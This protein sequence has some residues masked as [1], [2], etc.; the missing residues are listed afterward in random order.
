MKKG[1]VL[2]TGGAGFIGSHLCDALLDEEYTVVV[3]D[4]LCTGKKENVP[5]KAEFHEL[6]IC[7]EKIAD[8]FAQG[9][10]NA[11]CHLAAQNDV[12]TSVSKPVFD[13]QVN[14][15]GSINLLQN[16]VKANVKR[17]VFAST[18]G[19]IYGEA[20]SLPVDET[21][22]I[23]PESPYGITKHAVE[24]YMRYFS[25]LSNLE[26]RSLRLGNVFGP[27]QDPYG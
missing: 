5:E 18:G 15:L 16:C 3:V 11:V 9:S 12:R 23:R 20:D 25:D 2:V 8:L 4:N 13:A 24:H 26:V 7:S 17:F 10:F 1:K 6:D 27:R 22:P 14:I 21:H 19:A